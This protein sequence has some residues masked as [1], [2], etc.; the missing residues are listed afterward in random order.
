MAPPVS[1]GGVGS[2]EAQVLIPR[3]EGY[4]I[5]ELLGRGGMGTVWHAHDLNMNR[6]VALKVL[7]THALGSRRALQRFEREVS[8]ASRLEHPGI[9]RVYGSGIGAGTYYYI[10]EKIEGLPLDEYVRQRGLTRTQTLTLFVSLL[11]AIGYAHR[12]GVIHRDLKPSNLL[13]DPQGQPHILDFGL[14]TA[15]DDDELSLS[16]DG[17]PLGTL[18]YMAPEQARGQHDLI[19]ARS[20]L[21]SVGLMLFE[22]LLGELPYEPWTTRLE[23]ENRVNQ[24]ALRR[25]RAV[26]DKHPRKIDRDLEAILDKGL[27]EQ[28]EQRYASAE[29]FAADL[30]RYLR[31]EPVTARPLTWSYLTAR[32]LRKHWQPVTA[33]AAVVAVLLG[34]AVASYVQ[35]QRQ[36]DIARA[37]EQQA[38]AERVRAQL[39]LYFNQIAHAQ[40]LIDAG[41][42]GEAVTLLEACDPA[43]RRAEWAY[44]YRQADAS[45]WSQ[46]FEHAVEAFS[47]TP[48]GD[49]LA[50]DELG[51]LHRLSAPGRPRAEPVRLP[52]PRVIQASFVAAGRRLVTSDFERWM[53]WD[54]AEGK[55]IGEGMLPGTGT[56]N[57]LDQHGHTLMLGSSAYRPQP[58][59]RVNLAD[60]ATRE[61][62]PRAEDSRIPFTAG[63]WDGMFEKR[64]GRMLLFDANGRTTHTITLPDTPTDAVTADNRQIAVGLVS[65]R[66]VLIEPHPADQ[67]A[68]MTVRRV[69]AADQPVRSLALHRGW[70][71]A[72][73]EGRLV[74]VPT[75]ETQTV[76]AF[77][78]MEG[79]V[80]WV[81]VRDDGWLIAGASRQ[82]KAWD[83]AGSA[84]ALNDA[85]RTHDG[86]AASLTLFDQQ[87]RVAL[88]AFPHA[89]R[90]ARLTDHQPAWHI[91]LDDI[92]PVEL[93]ADDARGRLLVRGGTG[94]A[95]L[96]AASGQVVT[97]QITHAITDITVVD[98][99]H[100]LIATGEQPAVL[101]HTPS[102]QTVRTLPIQRPLRRVA[103]SAGVGPRVI[104]L[105]RDDPTRLVTIRPDDPADPARLTSLFK[106]DDPI[107]YLGK[108]SRG[109][110]LVR[111]AKR[112]WLLD[113]ETGQP[114]PLPYQTTGVIWQ[115]EG[116]R[117]LNLSTPTSR[118]NEWPD[119]REVLGLRLPK[120]SDACWLDHRQAWLY[121]HAAGIGAFPADPR[122]VDRSPVRPF[123]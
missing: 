65:G 48:Q 78:G 59:R 50:V 110:V 47:L 15:D 60:A 38:N 77:P 120:V 41:R 11:E 97:Q 67:G 28:P 10:M 88:V 63:A 82:I 103:S 73:G 116:S 5:G 20:D 26:A 96:D 115:T 109:T 32:R 108:P 83:L 12:C 113:L 90:A 44:L 45:A 99:T 94:W 13:I 55:V 57:T 6:E 112:Q 56:P 98:D 95:V 81:A 24:H 14:A 104:A 122:L 54:V 114:T 105:A 92:A 25:P 46:D 119:G 27:A 16:R 23:L 64:A 9:A 100:D 91:T 101:Y 31:D 4:Q 34:M 75:A 33:A 106:A 39:T 69:L 121:A 72:G 85:L 42:R 80:E 70:I 87:R 43:Y 49:L 118:L 66:V 68:T 89:I 107:D 79:I 76:F 29:E 102:G 30:R 19:D 40:G 111:T 61:H 22:A 18:A 51:R 7:G 58:T 53:V 117:G 62:L 123:D 36:R 8:L 17:S 86:T 93:E 1:E 3:V 84:W 2:P 52:M 37:N 21:Y 71:F 35:V 74:A